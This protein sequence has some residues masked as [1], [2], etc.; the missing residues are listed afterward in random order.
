MP[1]R[2]RWI[3]NSSFAFVFFF[4]LSTNCYGKDTANSDN[5]VLS[6][7]YEV[8]ETVDDL[9][10]SIKY[11]DAKGKN[12][13]IRKP[14]GLVGKQAIPAIPIK[15]WEYWDILLKADRDI[16]AEEYLK[17]QREP[18]FERTANWLAPMQFPHSFVGM[19]EYP[20]EVSVGWDGAIG[21]DTGFITGKE[22]NIKAQSYAISF[23]L[24][25]KPVGKNESLSIL[26]GQL[27]NYLPVIHYVYQRDS[28]KAG[29]EQIVFAGRCKERPVLFARFRLRN[30]SDTESTLTFSAASL[31]G[32]KFSNDKGQLKINVP[33]PPSAHGFRGVIS[34]KWD[35]FEATLIS[36]EPYEIKDGVPQWNFKLAPGKSKDLY[37][38]IPGYSP[39]GLAE[40]SPQGIR[41]QFFVALLEQKQDW[42][43]FFSRGIQI[44][45]PER[46]VYELFKSS[47]AKLMISIDGNECRGS[48]L[49]YEG[50]WAFIHLHTTEVMLQLGYFDEAKRYLEHL[51]KNRI[52][53]NGDFLFGPR[54]VGLH[55]T[56]D[57]GRFLSVLAMYYQYT[58]DE[59]L[60]L[61]NTDNIQKVISGIERNRQISMDKYPE[62]DLR[63]GLM[64]GIFNNDVHEET[65]YYTTDAP[66]W[67]GLRRYSKV[68]KQIADKTD[69]KELSAKADRMSEC[70]AE[71]H[72]LFRRSFDTAVERD[73][74]GKITFIH[75][76]P[77]PAGSSKPYIA[78]YRG[79][80][81]GK[82]SK[83]DRRLRA[84]FRFHE[85][86][87][88]I[89]SGFLTEEE[90]LSLYEYNRTWDKTVLGV[91]RYRDTRLDDFQSHSADFQMLRL[92][93]VREYLMKYYAYLH[94]II[95]P[96]GVGLEQSNIVPG[97]Y[98][99]DYLGSRPWP[100]P[101][102]QSNIDRDTEYPG[103]RGCKQVLFETSHYEGHDGAHATLP[104]CSLTRYIYM[105]D[106]P[107]PDKDAV[108]IARGIPT[109]WYEKDKTL[110]FKGLTSKFGRIDYETEYDPAKKQ[111][112]IEL[113]PEKHR[114]I[115]LAYIGVRAPGGL[116]PLSVKHVTEEKPNCSLDFQNNL[117]TI[118]D[119]AGKLKLVVIYE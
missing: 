53:P 78:P 18:S 63:Y 60:I 21:M 50:F 77:L 28:E 20:H 98:P 105:F 2:L 37:F 119:I 41:D 39:R 71:Y 7:G 69:N 112:T 114:S 40:I 59:S 115:P 35:R 82:N 52:K 12:I 47:L 8:I 93:L 92:G 51:I 89:G 75:P 85:R 86:T 96:G 117:V 66:V 9:S 49:Y 116:K 101:L 70:A 43:K 62:D 19:R 34:D 74:N 27:D 102:E 16:L 44:E 5:I 22:T 100:G 30:Y 48:A 61:D 57:E 73:K 38:A 1:T 87:R 25:G 14:Y 111:M 32:E 103:R 55:Q 15:S 110:T 58:Q 4:A 108:W 80:D 94:Y 99:H 36:S 79:D 56:F 31:F 97:E 3:F 42:E 106:D 95:M 118:K 64:T 109:H 104:V 23:I 113:L 26:R 90:I 17:D 29:W 54:G 91:R 46:S 6:N 76:G 68:L 10:G 33:Y 72:S 84:Q 13:L 11:E 83:V 65:E 81:Q 24:N 107:D 88:F 67:A 45:L